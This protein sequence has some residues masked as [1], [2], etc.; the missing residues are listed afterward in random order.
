MRKSFILLNLSNYGAG[1]IFS[2]FITFSY[3]GE[4][5]Y[6]IFAKQTVSSI[7]CL[8]FVTIPFE[9]TLVCN[10]DRFY[11]TYSNIQIGLSLASVIATTFWIGIS[12]QEWILCIGLVTFGSVCQ[13]AISLLSTHLIVRH[14]VVKS[15]VCTLMA[16]VIDFLPI[17]LLEYGAISNWCVAAYFFLIA[18][19]L[20][21]LVLKSINLIRRDQQ[22][23]D[24][25][26][27]R[28]INI[29][30]ELVLTNFL[31]S[32][33]SDSK[34]IFFINSICVVFITIVLT[35]YWERYKPGKLWLIC[36]IT[37]SGV[38]V[39]IS[40]FL[41]LALSRVVGFAC[42]ANHVRLL[43]GIPIVLGLILFGLSGPFDLTMYLAISGYALI[44]G[45]GAYSL[46]LMK[47]S[48]L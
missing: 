35:P 19:G 45:F 32:N 29:L 13:L 47:N 31:I 6:I 18:L 20:G 33:T 7:L 15:M 40:P 48:E 4:A 30:C 2:L 14:Q 5:S 9:R 37:I 10:Q 34:L 39:L 38:V 16:R 1:L 3:T 17:T 42:G 27:V 22:M 41:S 21:I 8:L 25:E 28:L 44:T 36:S 11:I 24:Y 12:T 46:R 43:V 26:A 23:L